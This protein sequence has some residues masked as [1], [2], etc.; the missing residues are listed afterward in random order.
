MAHAFQLFQ[1]PVTAFLIAP[2]MSVPKNPSS[3]VQSTGAAAPSGPTAAAMQMKRM[4]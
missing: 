2:P 1:L 3:G 4:A